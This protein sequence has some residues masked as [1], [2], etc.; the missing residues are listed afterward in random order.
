MKECLDGGER[1][2]R[3]CSPS[4][5]S[6]PEQS[7]VIGIVAPATPALPEDST[8]TDSHLRP[9]PHNSNRNPQE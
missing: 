2:K 5:V 1:Q 8:K 6:P 7:D 9:S 4:S 3:L